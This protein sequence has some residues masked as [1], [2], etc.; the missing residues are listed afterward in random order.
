MARDPGLAGGPEVKRGDDHPSAPGLQR[1]KLQVYTLT[2]K[3]QPSAALPPYAT[4]R[5][6]KEPENKDQVETLKPGEAKP[7]SALNVEYE[8]HKL[9]GAQ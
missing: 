9:H 5:N 3:P 7:H 1:S 2:L 8:N 4:K 6:L